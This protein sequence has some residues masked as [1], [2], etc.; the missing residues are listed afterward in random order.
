MTLIK[1]AFLK[2]EEEINPK[3]EKYDPE[4]DE[5]L[6]GITLE[7]RGDYYELNFENSDEAPKTKEEE[8]T[9]VLTDEENIGD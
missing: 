3:E 1:S 5:E 9:E 8:V 2:R 7:D 6:E 4:N